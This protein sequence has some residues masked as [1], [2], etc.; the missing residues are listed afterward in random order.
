MM[1]VEPLRRGLEESIRRLHSATE[2]GKNLVDKYACSS[3]SSLPVSNNTHGRRLVSKLFVT[4]FSRTSNQQEVL[5][6]MANI[7][8]FSQEEKIQVRHRY[9]LTSLVL[10]I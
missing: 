3:L 7:L 8:E 9:L 6:I 4:Y 2:N 5:A 10:G 1:L